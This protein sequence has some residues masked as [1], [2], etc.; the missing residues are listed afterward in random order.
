[1][2]YFVEKD[3]EKEVIAE[4]HAGGFT[5]YQVKLGVPGVKTL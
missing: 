3:Q 1:M 4:L 2:I 5:C